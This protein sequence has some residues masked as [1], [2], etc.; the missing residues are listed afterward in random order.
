MQR[1]DEFVEVGER[2]EARVDVA[3]VVDVVAA[4]GKC[5]R[6]ERAEPDRVDP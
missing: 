1:L 2:S 5:R 6:V 3:I 4:I